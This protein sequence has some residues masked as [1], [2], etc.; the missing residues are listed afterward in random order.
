MSWGW[1]RSSDQWVD[2][3]AQDPRLHDALDQ[4]VHDQ[5]RRREQARADRDFATADSIR[6]SLAA[7]GRRHRRHCRRTA[8]VARLRRRDGR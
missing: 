3:S 2:Q 1:I 8:L 7:A 6:D 5:L 4:L